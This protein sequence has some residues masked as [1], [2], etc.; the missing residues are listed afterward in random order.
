MNFTNRTAHVHLLI[1]IAL[2]IIVLIAYEEAPSNGFHFDDKVN[3]SEYEPVKINNISLSILSDVV[4][5][6]RLPRR[7]VAN[8]TFA[9]DWW[10]GDGNPSIFEWTNILIHWLNSALIFLL[11]VRCMTARYC[12]RD[13][14][15]LLAAGIGAGLWAAHP[16][17]VQAVTYIVQRM[18]QLALLFSLLSIHAYLFARLSTF[19][20]VRSVGWAFAITFG[21]FAVFSKENAWVLPLLWLLCECT[22][23]RRS[24][25]TTKKYKSYISFAAL[26]MV[27]LFVSWAL[28]GDSI[29]EYL[30]SGYDTR[31]FSLLERLLTQPRVLIYHAAQIIYPTLDRYGIFHDIQISKSIFEPITTI[32]ALVAVAI[33]CV[34]SLMYAAKY[35]SRHI[36]YF[37]LWI[38]LT[39]IIESSFI[40]LEMIFEHRMYMPTVGVAGLA[41]IFFYWMSKRNTWI[42]IISGMSCA[43]LLLYLVTVTRALVPTWFDNTTLYTQAIKTAPR[44]YRAH[45]NLATALDST[46]MYDAA[47]THYLY[48]L[49]LNPVLPEA[50][51]NLGL[52]YQKRGQTDIAEEQFR[53]AV[54]LDQRHFNSRMNLASLLL[55]R[56]DVVGALAMYEAARLINK[57]SIPGYLLPGNILIKHGKYGEAVEL[58]RL[59][60]EHLPEAAQLHNALGLAYTHLGRLRYAELSFREAIAFKPEYADAYNNI[61]GIA[62]STGRGALAREM[63]QNALRYDPEHSAARQ[64]LSAHYE[65]LTQ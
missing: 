62:L 48:A 14:S 1:F 55:E 33:W 54:E 28:W 50:L 64:N 57:A 65:R 43:A 17:Q 40:P 45:Y 12:V 6:G 20:V 2:L 3:I 5:N 39:L 32:L 9:I 51:N 41:A 11:V 44:S 4:M 34:I 7:A 46:G 59:G 47:E 19:S 42:K 60:I 61:G 36:G 21:I 52:I 35:S 30:K 10:R 37:A 29:N 8:I 58:F 53:M 16:I 25:K 49:K 27:M 38:P 15:I 26:A 31:D 18:A 23:V 63:F 24:P 22:I 13:I 56:P